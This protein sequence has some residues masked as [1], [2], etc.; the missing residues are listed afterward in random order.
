MKNEQLNERIENVENVENVD[1]VAKRRYTHCLVSYASIDELKPLLSQCKHYAYIYHDLDKT[2]P[3][4]HVIATFDRE[5][6]LAWI[7]K[8][9]PSDQ[10]TFGQSIKGDV[11]DVLLYFTHTKTK[12]EKHIYDKSLIVYDC[13][14]YW[15]KR[16]KDD[17]GEENPNDVFMDDLLSPSMSLEVMGRKYGRDFLKNMQ[18]YLK[19]RDFILEERRAKEFTDKAIE[20]EER[21]K[22]MELEEQRRRTDEAIAWL[23]SIGWQNMEGE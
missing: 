2:S 7:R 12:G 22:A 20:L 9:I 17:S 14:D 15:R 18:S 1:D 21:R 8:Q 19:A 5:K 16:S 10:N 11:D 6:S 3:H 23:N 4:Y 13:E